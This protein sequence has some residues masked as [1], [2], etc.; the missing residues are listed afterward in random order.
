MS[1]PRS[2]S[3]RNARRILPGIVLMVCALLP[4]H[5]VMHDHVEFHGSH[6]TAFED[7]GDDHGI[8]HDHPVVGSA[9]AR[10][11]PHIS[12]GTMC[13]AAPPSRIA[14]IAR[15]GRDARSFG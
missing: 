1:A 3:L 4:L 15:D 5:A 10:V 6:G 14:E 13:P 12:V 7:A 8:F 2:L 9:A 11:M